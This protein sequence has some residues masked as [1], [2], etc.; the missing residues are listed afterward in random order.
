MLVKTKKF[1]V[2]CKSCGCV[3]Y[4]RHPWNLLGYCWWCWSQ[5]LRDNKKVGR[6][7][8]TWS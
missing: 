3:N 4:T 1:V 7:V 2:R 5:R 6:V 8:K